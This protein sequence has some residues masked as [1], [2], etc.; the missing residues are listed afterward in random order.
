MDRPANPLVTGVHRWDWLLLLGWIAVGAVGSIVYSAALVA[1][2]RANAGTD[3]LD[4]SFFLVALIV[5]GPVVGVGQ[6]V[7]LHWRLR[8]PVASMAVWALGSTI[9]GW[10]VL[11]LLNFQDYA[12]IPS[13]TFV[14]GGIVGG[15]LGVFAGLVQA[16]VLWGRVWWAA[17]WVG[18]SV[19][20]TA[21][22]WPTAQ[23][24]GQRV[25]P[26]NH[27]ASLAYLVAALVSG[28]CLVGAV[29]W[30]HPDMRQQRD[31]WERV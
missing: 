9:G 18:V 4:G 1:F 12:Y 6:W 20:A 17:A 3:H 19:S 26:T 16:S 13:H 7:L 8:L 28:L 31:G 23:Y 2:Y 15:V 14:W 30:S 27:D 24:I 10:A 21:L 25:I 5:P 29:W 22:S 11:G